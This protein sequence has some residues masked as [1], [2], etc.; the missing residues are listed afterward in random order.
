M[1]DHLES[2]RIALPMLS[3]PKSASELRLSVASVTTSLIQGICLFAVGINWAKVALGITSVAASGG[4]S[5]IHSDP[6]RYGL[7]Y[8][9]AILATATLWVIWNGWRLRKSSAARWRKVPLT[10]REKWNIGLG[11]ASSILSWVLIV[12]E[13]F[14]HQKMHPR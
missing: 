4:S 13:V 6:V 2:S 8:L 1:E 10:S 12:A 14:A 7:R 9:S 11:L 5:F 3:E